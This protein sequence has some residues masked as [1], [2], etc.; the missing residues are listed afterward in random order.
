MQTRK[1]NKS[2]FKEK[3]TKYCIVQEWRS[4]HWKGSIS[5]SSHVKY[6]NLYSHTRTILHLRG[7]KFFSSFQRC[8]KNDFAHVPFLLCPSYAFVHIRANAL[9]L[10]HYCVLMVSRNGV[11][12]R[13]Q[14]SLFSSTASLYSTLLPFSLFLLHPSF[15]LRLAFTMLPRYFYLFQLAPFPTPIFLPG[16]VSFPFY[17]HYFLLSLSLSD[18]LPSLRRERN[19][20]LNGNGVIS[21][22]TLPSVITPAFLHL[23][24]GRYSYM[25]IIM[26]IQR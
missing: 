24:I 3:S 15:H 4:L 17:F 14:F 6:F 7:I 2:V 23:S 10:V 9:L 26:F 25:Y 1:R 11:T 19:S 8:T 21:R 18:F 22:I 5:R 20:T 13:R 16:G 12:S